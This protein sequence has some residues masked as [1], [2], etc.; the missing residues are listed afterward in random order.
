MMRSNQRRYAGS[1]TQ[2]SK[3]KTENWYKHRSPVRRSRALPQRR[4]SDA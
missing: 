1:A 4:D 2:N 3:L